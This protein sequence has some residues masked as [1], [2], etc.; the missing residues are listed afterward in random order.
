MTMRM[1]AIGVALLLAG[2]GGDAEREAPV[3][4]QQRTTPVVNQAEMDVVPMQTPTPT[5]TPSI[6]PADPGTIAAVPTA[7]RG[8]WAGEGGGCA[9]GA[10][11]RLQVAPDRLI[12]FEAEAVA[13]R[14][15][16]LSERE[17]ALDLRFSGEGQSWDK[18][19]V[20]TLGED[21]GTLVR[22]EGGAPA[23]RYRRCPVG[24]E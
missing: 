10:E 7:W 18:R 11:Q 24:D 19:N 8:V 14:I 17:V 13:T 12:F 3:E 20:L 9:P 6:T 23:V 1:A 21:A 15:E 2:C 5:P 22:S 16:R 4:R